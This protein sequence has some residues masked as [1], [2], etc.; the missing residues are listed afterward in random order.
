MVRYCSESS[1]HRCRNSEDEDEYTIYTGKD[2]T[3][4]SRNKTAI[5]CCVQSASKL[6]VTSP[7]A[8]SGDELV[9]RSAISGCRTWPPPY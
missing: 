9:R 6:Q 7:V 3:V 4:K 8:P 1:L 5:S 2:N